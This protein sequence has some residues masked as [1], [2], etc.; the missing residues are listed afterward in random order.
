M[1]RGLGTNSVTPHSTLSPSPSGV[2]ELTL[3]IPK[4]KVDEWIM[5]QV[6]EHPLRIGETTVS[7]YVVANLTGR[8]AGETLIAR[9]G[10]P[11]RDLTVTRLAARRI[12]NVGLSGDAVALYVLLVLG[13]VVS[14]TVAVGAACATE[15]SIECIGE[16]RSLGSRRA[17]PGSY[18]YLHRLADGRNSLHPRGNRRPAC[19]TQ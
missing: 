14:E 18:P 13:V 10:S 9:R 8:L 6:M 4:H 3:T 15:G 11:T 17:L 12:G 2:V 19:N 5:R 1:C 7:L 16:P